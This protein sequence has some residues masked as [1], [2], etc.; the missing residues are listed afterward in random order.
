MF[1]AAKVGRKVSKDVFQKSEPDLR[2][3]LLAAQ[4]SLREQGVTTLVLV[5]GMEGAGKGDVVNRLKEWLDARGVQVQAF[6]DETE[7]EKERPRFWRFWRALPPRSEIA[8]LFGGWYQCPIEQRFFG[9]WN[10]DQL[11]RELRRIREF[12][13]MLIEDGVLIVKFWYHYAEKDQRNRLKKLARDDRSRWKML[14]KKAKFSDQYRLFEHV[15]D[16]AVRKTDIGRAPWY[17]IEASDRR[18]RDLTT[19]QTL[20]RAMETHLE[21]R[22][23]KPDGDE[24]AA[25][26]PL[27]PDD[28]NAQLTLIDT[29]DQSQTLGKQVY[30][31]ELKRLQNELNEL[32]WRAYKAGRTTVM[33]F[34]G[35]DAG[36]KGGAI[37]RVTNA[38][39]ARLYRVVSV[40]APTDE[41]MAHHYL[42]RFWRH[43]PRAGRMIVFDRSWYGRVLVERVEG[44]TT[45]HHW[46]RA[47]LEINDFEE[48]LVDS[49][50]IV[51]KFWLQISSD[52]QLARFKAREVTPYK[53]HKITDEDWRNRE[54]WD[55]YRLAV[56]EMLVRTSTES[57][58]WTLV[59]GDNKRSARIQ[60]L[61]TI[62]ETLSDALGKT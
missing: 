5:A 62:S 55:D 24:P 60:V 28:P 12:E 59:A 6:W 19:G 20:L 15:A 47:Y 17:V 61:N 45:P 52:E 26:S 41:E 44:F 13:R 34:E 30:D 22:E 36:G 8:I 11:E 50:A 46:Q 18:Y 56:N 14:P 58:P 33:V 53:Q 42:W 4:R 16:I 31:K 1:E 25:G 23:V 51:L 54:K 49:G 39:D 7:E 57:A 9:H 2:T 37:R 40:A 32:A 48:Q 35:V 29:V 43:I 10:D 27:L 21:H 38:I 3:R